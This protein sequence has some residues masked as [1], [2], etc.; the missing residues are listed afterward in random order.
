MCKWFSSFT[1]C[2]ML[3]NLAFLPRHLQ[4][5]LRSPF[6]MLILGSLSLSCSLSFSSW[7]HVSQF[8][9]TLYLLVHVFFSLQQICTSVGSMTVS[10]WIMCINY[11]EFLYL[12]IETCLISFYLIKIS[13]CKILCNKKAWVASVIWHGHTR[14]LK[15]SWHQRK[16]VGTGKL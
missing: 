3:L 12:Q 1:S 10:V 2:N 16:L 7:S 9:H 5:C 8:L 15:L 6:L 13:M 4:S 14:V 11:S